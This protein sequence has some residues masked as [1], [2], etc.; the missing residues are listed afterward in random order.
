MVPKHRSGLQLGNICVDHYWLFVLFILTKGKELWISYTLVGSTIAAIPATALVKEN[1]NRSDA[2][3][4]LNKSDSW[5]AN[6]CRRHIDE[7]GQSF[8]DKI[9]V[10]TWGTKNL[11]LRYPTP[12]IISFFDSIYTQ[13]GPLSAKQ[14]N[15]HI[16]CTFRESHLS[17]YCAPQ[18]I[19][20]WVFVHTFILAFNIHVEKPGIFLWKI[21]VRFLRVAPYWMGTRQCPTGQVLQYGV[22]YWKY[23]V[24]GQVRVG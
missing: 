3:K 10:R 6:K 15:R 1:Y 14:P 16:F 5:I 13:G 18:K 19:L 20:N 21:N 11:W 22:R 7:D 23:Q 4:E 12:Q 9:T 8:S 24:S 17:K 2:D